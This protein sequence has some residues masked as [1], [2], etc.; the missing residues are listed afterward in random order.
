MSCTFFLDRDRAVF[1]F[2]YELESAGADR[3]RNDIFVRHC[4]NASPELVSD[5]AVFLYDLTVGQFHYSIVFLII[6]LHGFIP[7]PLLPI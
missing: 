3:C 1:R 5:V 4:Q 7:F 6:V 2:D